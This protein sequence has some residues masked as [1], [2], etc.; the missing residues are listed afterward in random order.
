[1][2]KG[3]C[4]SVWNRQINHDMSKYS[5]FVFLD[6]VVAIVVAIVEVEY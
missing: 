3:G 6:R 5:K 1:M 4:R 2:Q